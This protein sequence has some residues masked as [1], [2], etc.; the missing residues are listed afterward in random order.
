[1]VDALETLV[2]TP[3]IERPLAESVCAPGKPLRVLHAINGEHYAGAERVQDLL[4]LRLPEFG[5]E[6]SFACLKGREFPEKR[7]AQSAPLHALPMAFRLDPRTIWALRRLVRRGGYAIVHTH[8]PRAALAGA[9]ALSRLAVPMV[10][11]M[12]SPASADT[13]RG[14]HDRLIALSERLSLRRA[15]AVITVSSSLGRY[16]LQQE[17]VPPQRLVVVPNGVPR[18]ERLPARPTPRNEWLLGAVALFRP[19]KGLEVLLEA[20][21]ILRSRG[22]HVRLRAVGAFETPEYRQKMLDLVEHWSLTDV[23]QWAGFQ[24]D[25]PRELGRLDLFVLPS[26][27]GEGMPMVVLEAMAAGVPVVATRVEGVPEA[28]RDGI[29]GVLAPPGDPAELAAAIDRLF[30][31]EV[32]WSSLRTSAFAR[33]A[34]KF[35]DRSMAAAVADVYRRVLE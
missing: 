19:R 32:D 22:R 31:G 9:M 29:D 35:S 4:A 20:L 33:Q 1:M 26:L 30:T 21:A 25:V 28:I 5:F 15:A 10:H 24:S 6:V 14:L 17:L 16:V 23:V 18:L 11:H 12:H 34:Q 3:S 2:A 13:D 7:S 8:G 27:Y